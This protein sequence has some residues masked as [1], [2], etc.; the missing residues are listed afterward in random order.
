VEQQAEPQI[1]IINCAEL[2]KQWAV[3]E[4]WVRE[5]MRSRASDP[6]PHLRLGRYRRV[7]FGS[8]ELDSWLDRHRAGAKR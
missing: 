3:P 6:I 7:R 1:T 4:S 2:A 8:P 5:Q